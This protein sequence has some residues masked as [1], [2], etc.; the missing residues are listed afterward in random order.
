MEQLYE[1]HKDVHVTFKRAIQTCKKRHS[2]IV[3]FCALFIQQYFRFYSQS[4][5]L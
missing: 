1:Q 3:F 2:E 5:K 4:D